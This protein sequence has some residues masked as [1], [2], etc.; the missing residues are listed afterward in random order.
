MTG[1]RSAP[2]LKLPPPSPSA[3]VLDPMEAGYSHCVDC[4]GTEDEAIFMKVLGMM[5]CR[6]CDRWSSS[7]S[8]NLSRKKRN[9]YQG[10]PLRR[11]MEVRS[12]VKAHSPINKRQL[13]AISGSTYDVTNFLLPLSTSARYLFRRVCLYSKVSLDWDDPVGEEAENMIVETLTNMMS[14]HGITFPR[15]FAP[16]RG[17]KRHDHSPMMV[18]TTDG[19]NEGLAA[20]IYGVFELLDDDPARKDGTVNYV[21]LIKSSARLAPLSGL[22]TPKTEISSIQLGCKLRDLV[23]D[24]IGGSIKFNK[25][26]FLSDSQCALAQVSARFSLFESYFLSRIREIQSKTRYED[27]YFVS[28]DKNPSDIPSKL[29]SK[30]LN[31]L[32]NSQLWRRGGFLMKDFSEWPIKK[33]PRADDLKNLTGVHPKYRLHSNFSLSNMMYLP[34]CKGGGHNP[35]SLKKWK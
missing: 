9:Q 12:Y 31:H 15:M 32:L 7:V 21:S 18:V 29:H 25:I 34:N 27:F 5:L 13:A 28:G 17:Y 30:P 8:V 4:L 24:E 16:A 14:A 35:P 11:G 23:L 10:P 22:S 26:I 1:T 19:S 6:R 2:N 20:V 3:K 33:I